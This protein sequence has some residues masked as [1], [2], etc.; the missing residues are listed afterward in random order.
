V[1][2]VQACS[3]PILTGTP[4]VVA[5]DSG[6]GEVVS[7]VGGGTVVPAG[8]VE[9]LMNAIAAALHDRERPRSAAPAASVRVRERY[10]REAV[11]RAL[12]EVYLELCPSSALA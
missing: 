7:K 10:S 1:T 4:V 5:D 6:C 9:A 11:C 12:E 3:L 2:G 8:D